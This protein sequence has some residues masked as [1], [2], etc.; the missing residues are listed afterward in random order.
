MVTRI[1][2]SSRTSAAEL[3][4]SLVQP[5]QGFF[6]KHI[7]PKLDQLHSDA[8]TLNA[9][10]SGEISISD[11]QPQSCTSRTQAEQVKSFEATFDL[12]SEEITADEALTFAFE[13]SNITTST[14]DKE[15]SSE[16]IKLLDNRLTVDMPTGQKSFA[17]KTLFNALAGI[18]ARSRLTLK[19]HRLIA[20]F[21]YPDSEAISIVTKILR[22]DPSFKKMNKQ[23]Q[24]EKI[25]SFIGNDIDT[26]VETELPPQDLRTPKEC[27]IAALQK[28]LGL[29]TG[30]V[31]KCIVGEKEIGQDA[32]KF[33]FNIPER[34]KKDNYFPVLKR[35]DV[36]FKIKKAQHSVVEPISIGKVDSL[37]NLEVV[38]ESKKNLWEVTTLKAYCSPI[39]YDFF[40]GLEN[41]LLLRR[42]EEMDGKQD[43]KRYLEN[44]S[45]SSEGYSIFGTRK[46]LR[47]Q[48]RLIELI[49]KYLKNTNKDDP[50]HK[51][52][53]LAIKGKAALT[54]EWSYVLYKPDAGAV[55]FVLLLQLAQELEDTQRDFLSWQE[56]DGYL[57]A[58]VYFQERLNYLR[59]A[60]C[61]Y[62][63]NSKYLYSPALETL[64]LTYQ[65]CVN[66]LLLC[67][68]KAAKDN[69]EKLTMFQSWLG[70]DKAGCIKTCWKY[71]LQLTIENTISEE[72]ILMNWLYK[73]NLLTV[74]YTIASKEWFDET[75]KT[76]PDSQSKP[77]QIIKELGLL[78][79]YIA[80]TN[81]LNSRLE[82]EKKSFDQFIC[83]TPQES[84]NKRKTQLKVFLKDYIKS[85][86]REISD[87]SNV[88]LI[89][90]TTEILSIRSSILNKASDSL[91][92]K[93]LESLIFYQSA[94]TEER[95]CFAAKQLEAM[96]R[97]LKEGDLIQ[98]YTHYKSLCKLTDFEKTDKGREQ[99]FLSKLP[100]WIEGSNNSLQTQ[101]HNLLVK[102]EFTL[103]IIQWAIKENQTINLVDLWGQ[104]YQ[105]LLKAT[106]QPQSK[107]QPIFLPYL[108]S[109]RMFA[110]I[111]LKKTNPTS[112]QGL[113]E[114]IKKLKALFSMQDIQKELSCLTYIGEALEAKCQYQ[115][116]FM[117]HSQQTLDTLS[118]HE[119]SKELMA[120]KA[121]Q[122]KH[123]ELIKNELCECTFNEEK[124]LRELLEVAENFI[125][126]YRPNWR[127]YSTFE[128]H[129]SELQVRAS[130]ELYLHL[131]FYGGSITDMIKAIDE[132]EKKQS[133]DALSINQKNSLYELYFRFMGHSSIADYETVK[134]YYNKL[135]VEPKR[136]KRAWP[137]LANALLTLSE[138][139]NVSTEIDLLLTKFEHLFPG[140]QSY[141]STQAFAANEQRIKLL[142]K[143]ALL[144]LKLPL[145]EFT[146]KDIKGLSS[147][148]NKKELKKL[149]S[150]KEVLN[151]LPYLKAFLTLDNSN[152]RSLSIILGEIKTRICYEKY[153]M[154]IMNKDCLKYLLDYLY[155]ELFQ[156]K[157][158]KLEDLQELIC[159]LINKMANAMLKRI[160]NDNT[161]SILDLIEKWETLNPPGV[162]SEKILK[163]LSKK[164]FDQKSLSEEIFVAKAAH[165]FSVRGEAICFEKFLL[166]M[167][168]YKENK[169]KFPKFTLPD[170]EKLNALLTKLSPDNTVAS[171]YGESFL[172]SLRKH[173]HQLDRSYLQSHLETMK[174]H[175]LTTKVLLNDVSSWLNKRMEVILS[176]KR[177][178]Y[179][180][181]SMLI[182]GLVIYF[183]KRYL[184]MNRWTYIYIDFP[185]NY[186]GMKDFI[187]KKASIRLQNKVFPYIDK[188]V[189]RICDILRDGT[190]RA[191]QALNGRPVLQCPSTPIHMNDFFKDYF[192]SFYNI[193]CAKSCSPESYGEYKQAM[194][195]QLLD[196]EEKND[197][198]RFDV[199]FRKADAVFRAMLRI[200]NQKYDE[201]IENFLD[202]GKQFPILILR[203]H[204]LVLHFDSHDYFLRMPNMPS[205]LD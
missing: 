169:E 65:G 150:E 4:Y 179:T 129:L 107:I 71:W 188:S 54:G 61:T 98:A 146:E 43:R 75:C 60:Y 200:M 153:A 149:F 83:I 152:E 94:N 48:G 102:T 165:Y 17:Y 91:T 196:S 193:T 106:E 180:L 37:A 157:S 136:Q 19:S 160:V 132:F 46:P 100:D 93:E 39:N 20:K 8:F 70:K 52:I 183:I 161:Q 85:H 202:I 148:K 38:Y 181:A 103:Q 116:Y 53:K 57:Q 56:K 80:L 158:I 192:H 151:D 62:C 86:D 44:R 73:K 178:F 130:S 105:C 164:N 182:V 198:V 34:F 186:E 31:E 88:G 104:A 58:S 120:L 110:E 117:E 76:Q 27:V 30:Q 147:F 203:L 41:V 172:I 159:T 11:A 143:K 47:S 9:A 95:T 69:S 163:L 49:N 32:Y 33:S 115:A 125:E 121:F 14:L 7:Q 205:C 21:V 122:Y 195:A 18:G 177:T 99:R 144:S 55:P 204:E 22:C 189:F 145:Q 124:R 1:V 87:D 131:S 187:G 84:L 2:N 176:N 108:A 191:M 134:E 140:N 3:L 59:V 78:E 135:S 24:L 66:S 28:F 109:L 81:C 123:E 162:Y 194:L 142:Y 133:Q 154:N 127:T 90:A 26:E 23:E 197:F 111:E 68:I 12:F 36:L 63:H 118:I 96:N 10:S 15:T 45:Q 201:S 175:W 50:I 171:E 199:L 190:V 139:D 112:L 128:K 77:E 16:L 114:L 92:L 13:K 173:L 25:L 138:A 40:A 82:A 29:K 64:R 185:E 42:A 184:Y 156:G 126:E 113:P 168:K 6:Q 167:S 101:K 119:I 170:Q 97:H 155:N 72:N 67:K 137:I 166:L 89:S 141:S 51:S 174:Q 74:A 5:A 35:L 79:Q